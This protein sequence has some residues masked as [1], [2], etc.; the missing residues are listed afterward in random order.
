VTWCFQRDLSYCEIQ[1]PLQR[2]GAFFVYNVFMIVY[3]ISLISWFVALCF[4]VAL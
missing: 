2:Q 1:V 4:C 3:L